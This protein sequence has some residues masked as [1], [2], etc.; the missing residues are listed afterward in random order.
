MVFWNT[1]PL[2]TIIKAKF[3]ISQFKSLIF[4]KPQIPSPTDVPALYITPKS[5]K[6]LQ[7]VREFIRKTFGGPPSKPIL[8]IPES[9]ILGARDF[10]WRRLMLMEI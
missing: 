10:I 5:P 1:Y 3:N 7:E 4:N 2:L 8:D 6:Y 9:D